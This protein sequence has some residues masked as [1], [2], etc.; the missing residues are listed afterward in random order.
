MI[1][2][3]GRYDGFGRVRRKYDYVVVGAGAGGSVIAA[4]LAEV[5]GVSVLVL[6]A[7]PTDLSP[8]IRMPAAQA[9]PLKDERRTWRFET[10]P[11]PG[12]DNRV[13]PHL[14]GRM[15]GGSSSLNGMVYVRGNPRDFDAWAEAGNPTWSYAHCLPYFRKL[16]TYDK[17]ADAYRGGDGPVHVSTMKAELPIFQAFLRAGQQA[18]QV[19]N[20]DYNGYRQE[21][22][23][24]H[25]AN[26]DHGTRDSAA[27]A[28]LWPALRGGQVEIRM[29]APA[30]RVRFNDARHAV[31]VEFR[32]RGDLAFVEAEREVILCGGAYGSPHLLLLS[33]VG[34]RAHLSKHAIE[35]VAEVPGVGRSLQDHPCVGVKYRSARAGVSPGYNMNLLKMA[36]TGA[37]WLFARAGLGA[38]NLWETGSFFKSHPDVDYVNIQHEFVPLLG[39]YGQGKMVVEE[40]FYYS[41]CLMRPVSRGALELVSAD[42]RTAPR[43]V[44]NYLKASED[45]R[46]LAAAVKHTDEIIQQSAWDEIRG[47]GVSPPL[48]K[49]PDGEILR[50]LRANVST[51]YHPCSTCRMGSDGLAVVDDTARVHGVARLRVVDASIMP[52]ITSGNLQSPTLMLAEKIADHIKGVLLSPDPQDYADKRH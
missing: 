6:E 16:E 7:G 2:Y 41:T 47:E 38:S 19:F 42:P 26:V 39:D 45:Q 50:W 32:L 18:G 36:W 14:R 23:H 10:G 20:A 29:N 8:F 4:R 13:I 48:R 21:G 27:R 35:T 5:P 37:R 11:E 34:D 30:T 12:L 22:I 24:I 33:G 51:Q 40:G 43:I 28:Y 15:V 46:A 49:M 44:H 1:S 52:S 17:G 31:G 3:I 25:Q 9:Y